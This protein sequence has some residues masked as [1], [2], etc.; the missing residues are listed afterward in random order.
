MRTEHFERARR[1]IKGLTIKDRVRRVS[2]MA[3]DVRTS[4]Q[5]TASERRI[6]LEDLKAALE[7]RGPVFSLFVQY[8]STR[9][10]LFSA[11]ECETL[12]AISSPHPH[13][14]FADVQTRVERELG[15]SVSTIFLAVELTP[16]S[17]A[18]LADSYLALLST[19]E[20]VSITVLR[21]EFVTWPR[22]QT[23]ALKVFCAGLFSEEWA[24]SL[25]GRVLAGF[26]Q[27]LRERVDL[28]NDAQNVDALGR[29]ARN[30]EVLWAPRIH[31]QLCRPSLL[32]T[33]RFQG[34]RL[35]EVIADYARL[36]GPAGEKTSR[37]VELSSE[38]LARFLC[39]AWLRQVFLGRVF[40]INCSG[41][42]VF[43]LRDGRI[44]FSVSPFFTLPTD[45]SEL[46]WK[47]LLAVAADDPDECC[48]TLL[49]QTV[50]DV[51]A[52][53]KREL[54]AQFRQAVTFFQAGPGE[55]DLYTGTAAR[56]QRQLELVK[57]AGFRLRPSVL[58]FYRGL[59]SLLSGVRQLRPKRDSLL[60]A[61]E[62]VW[63]SGIFGSFKQMTQ[64]DIFT[65]MA[66]KYAAAMIELPRRLNDVLTSFTHTR[67]NDDSV[68]HRGG[69]GQNSFSLTALLLLVAILILVRSVSPPI[70]ADWAGRITF[71]TCCLIGFFALKI[72]GS[73][74]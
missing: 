67:E 32:V 39:V 14:P 1:P 43:V 11:W 18:L 2:A 49:L 20:S 23:E 59:F 27:E 64:P 9:I 25:I 4:R 30:S 33:E 21:E 61:I 51:K 63:V 26:E 68:G 24:P 6:R 42:D 53:R 38:K 17:G 66:N 71:A 48:C 44:S 3:S 8:L 70:P 55:Q 5:Q 57:G 16:Y 15:A 37:V 50:E 65:D 36:G 22:E 10:D 45:I 34:A 12:A 60:E 7:E 54:L 72:A 47:Y 46:V 62:D 13:R 40:P 73:S 31:Q 74:S 41:E 58:N 19:G 28:R 69:N 56:I 29:D 52:E 35:S